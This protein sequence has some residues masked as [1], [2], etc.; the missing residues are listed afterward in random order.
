MMSDLVEAYLMT[1]MNEGTSTATPK[2]PATS[3]LCDR[4]RPNIKM[5]KTGAK[6]FSIAKASPRF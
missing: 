1:S 3:P 6:D 4:E 5:Q 2:I